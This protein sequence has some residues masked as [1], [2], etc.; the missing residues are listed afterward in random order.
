[1]LQGDRIVPATY[2]QH[3]FFRLAVG[4]RETAIA[5]LKGEHQ[6]WLW[7]LRLV[8]FI[9]MWL[10]LWLI[11]GPISAILDVIPLLGDMAD[12]MSGTATL[13]V[14]FVLSAVTILVSSIFYQPWIL[15][16]AVGITLVSLL[17][18]RSLLR[19]HRA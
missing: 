17:V 2:K 14:A 4:S 10:G 16:G 7:L 9:L 12:F 3:A 18:G 6:M 13:V 8:G 19:S 15:A 5:D 1:M 11:V